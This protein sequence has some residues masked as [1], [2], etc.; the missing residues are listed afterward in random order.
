MKIMINGGNL[1]KCY[2]EIRKEQL[3]D[4]QRKNDEDMVRRRKR[5]CWD[6]EKLINLIEKMNQHINRAQYEKPYDPIT[7]Q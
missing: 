4:G 6:V 2:E 5:Y 1:G 3:E 7:R